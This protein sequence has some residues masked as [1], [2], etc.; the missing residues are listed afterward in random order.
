VV[1]T[2]RGGRTTD[3]IDVGAIWTVDRGPQSK[4]GDW[5]LILPVGVEQRKSVGPDDVP[6][7][8]TGN[9]T[10]DLIDGD[11]ARFIQVGGLTIRVGEKALRKTDGERPKGEDKQTILIEQADKGA[12]ISIDE[13]GTITI[14][15]AKDIVLD[16]GSGKISLTAGDVDVKVSNA[17]DVHG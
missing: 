12:R 1:V 6:A 5:W 8:H 14:K 16:A 7:E 13:D 2:H 9:V 4:P 17:M 10:D 3:P 11:G 15:S